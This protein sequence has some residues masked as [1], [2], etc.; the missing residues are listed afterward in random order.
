MA[1]LL[2]TGCRHEELEMPDKMVPEGER[3]ELSFKVAVPSDGTATKAMGINPTIDT[4][5]FY[6][7]VFGGSGYFNEWVKATV[8]AATANYDGS[9]N[10]VYTIT[11]SLTVSD[12]RLRL[13]FIANC[14]PSI[15]TSPPISGSS[16]TEE[17]VMSHIRSQLT[18]TY[19]DGY[20]QKV[21]LPNGV[22]ATKNAQGV[23]VAT[24]A[25]LKQL[26]NPIIMVRNFARVYL[27]N[28]TPILI[29]ET[30]GESHQLVT[31]KK[32][33]LAYAP[34]EGVI[35]PI[36]SAPYMSTTTGSPI[37]VAEDDETT[38]VYYE[39][40]LMNYQRYPIISDSPSDTLVTA[41]PFNYGGF[42]PSDQAYD[43]Y[44]AEGH[45]DRGTPLESDLSN[46]DAEHPENNVLFVYE[47]TIPSV[48]KRA[49]RL[50]IQAERVDQNG[51]SEG[52][53]FYA[54][55]I[56]NTEGV[57]IPI[58]RNQTYTVHLLN[59]ESGSGET[60]ISKASQA[61]SATVSGDP[62]FQNLVN[63]SD[64]KS[65]IGT[66][67]TE[68]FYV[69]PQE[70]SVMFRYL[71][72][73][74]GDETY[75]ANTEGNELVTIKVGSFD[76]EHGGFT[77]LTPAQAS[78]QGILAF[79]TNDAGDEY[80]VWIVKDQDDKAISYVRSNNKWV[81]ATAAQI[82]DPTIE[83]W[84]MIRYQL[85]ESYMD[86]DRFFTAER[87]QA[88][89]VIGS[90][91][92][93]V[94]SRDVIIKTSPRQ[95]MKVRCL[96]KYVKGAAGEEEVV[97]IMMPTGLSR[98]VFPLEFT[99]EADNY[100]LTPNGD[101]MPVTYGTSTIPDVD[102]P[103]FYFVKT[104]PTETDYKAL[105]TIR[106]E[107]DITWKYIDC[108]FKTTVAQNAS[109]VYV[110]SHFFNN[111]DANDEFFNYEQRLFTNQSGGDIA[112]ANT[113]Y[114]N[115]ST[116]FSFSL[117]YANRN[118]NHVWWDPTNAYQQSASAEEAREK[119]LS[120]S[121]RVLP[122]I[123]SV[124]LDGFTPT[125]EAN[126]HLVHSYGNTYLY[127]VGTGAPTSDMA[128]ISLSLTAT[129]NI[130]STGTVTLSTA[131]I[132]E[133]PDL[134]VLAS[135][136]RQISGASLSGS[137]SPSTLPLGLYQTTSF[138]FT[139][140]DGLVEPVTIQLSGLKLHGNDARMRANGDGSYTFTPTDVNTRTYS[141]S[142]E[143]TTRYSA[144]SIVLENEDY[145]PLTVDIPR[146]GSI[147]IPAGTIYARGYEDE[148]HTNVAPTKLGNR[149][150]TISFT[151][152]GSSVGSVTFNTTTFLNTAN[153]TVNTNSFA[154]SDNTPVYFYYTNTNRYDGQCTLDEIMDVIEG[155]SSQ[156]RL[157][158]YR[159]TTGTYSIDF[160]NSGNYYT[161]DH[162]FSDGTSAISAAFS[163]CPGARDW[164]LFGYR[165][166]RKDIGT[167][168]GTAGTITISNGTLT[169]CKLTGVQFSYFGSYNQRVV[170]VNNVSVGAGATS[171][172][173][174]NTGEGNGE[175]S[176]TVRMLTNTSGTYKV[177]AI[178][179]LSINYGY[180]DY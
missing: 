168:D 93:R 174:T 79:K 21:I 110:D 56:V 7:A 135:A 1:I 124:T 59:I 62:D 18:D 179:N 3:V 171:W 83:K 155:T 86:S 142:L 24:T 107:N 106:D 32:F 156:I 43:Y 67:F 4:D 159:W 116:T 64:G 91:D 144:G 27:R 13:H 163:N 123:I 63:I 49:T 170:Y 80:K 77:E 138:S 60:D 131:N 114:R 75:A 57:A 103:A 47:R 23:Y 85:S 94:M 120:T 115:G 88:I 151:K 8:Q 105:L 15:R 17:Y 139:Y 133:N 65:S 178:T 46:W 134:Y 102:T 175:T 150:V 50:I 176:I 52:D 98:S 2:L 125:Y 160:T 76:S 157:N 11:A 97:R 38:A 53:K 81:E 73:S 71:P 55:D 33:G 12:S 117:D 16:D 42:S 130:G 172:T 127:Y 177:N 89:H 54:L 95:G 78:A 109:A 40:F 34:S 111:E 99:I 165:N 112:L 74:I 100:S 122:P 180:W 158:L 14:P 161:S 96:Q 140:A 45:L 35:A 90:Y 146:A 48:G 92:D 29:N 173:S 152:G 20:W 169:G 121:Y 108:P 119:G 126:P 164:G 41:A 149:A 25:T 141:I 84:G 19:N 39:N 148:T 128:N 104:I 147:V 5:G 6:I 22:R 10:T 129:G 113:I 9:N 31:I 118:K 154:L 26:P 51:V 145:E 70:D 136:S 36:L 30:T 162:T 66:S 166:Y 44:A 58:L 143:S 101:I 153:V 132:T 68:K 87:S 82:E 72:T 167:D 37:T 69:E 28:L 137:F 61:T